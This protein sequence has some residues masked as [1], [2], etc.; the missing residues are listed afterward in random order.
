[1]KNKHGGV[2]TSFKIDIIIFEKDW[3]FLMFSRLKRLKRLKFSPPWLPV[4]NSPNKS[5]YQVGWFGLLTR[6]STF[7][8]NLPSY[9][10]SSRNL[11]PDEIL[12][13]GN[14][15]LYFPVPKYYDRYLLPFELRNLQKYRRIS[16]LIHIWSVNVDQSFYEMQMLWSIVTLYMS[17]D[18]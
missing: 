13:F 6:I 7:T 5:A 10:A 17:W 2:T 15:N 3:H 1:M 18:K 12:L 14:I 11:L 16:C 9:E 4:Y 8:L